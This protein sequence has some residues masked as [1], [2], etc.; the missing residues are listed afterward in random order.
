MSD[1]A[2][3]RG[4]S[5]HVGG[6]EAL[7]LHGCSD[8]GDGRRDAQYSQHQ[9]RQLPHD[10]CWATTEPS[11][12]RRPFKAAGSAPRLPRSCGAELLDATPS[13]PSHVPSSLF[14][15][16]LTHISWTTTSTIEGGDKIFGMTLVQ[17]PPFPMA[18]T[19]LLS[20]HI[21]RSHDN[22]CSVSVQ[23]MCL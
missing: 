2:G 22:P 1:E 7:V 6:V 9:H 11:A 20:S 4:R 15:T 23:L 14:P 16:A 8:R 5:V 3:G 21:K 10:H 13:R 12:P 17:S 19:I 18:L